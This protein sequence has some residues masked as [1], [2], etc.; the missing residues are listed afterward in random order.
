MELELNSLD[1]NGN[2]LEH[3]LEL[4]DTKHIKESISRI[5][6]QWN[7]DKIYVIGTMGIKEDVFWIEVLVNSSFA[8]D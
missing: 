3:E 6:C 8:N 5:R 7:S 1:W 4:E 2:E